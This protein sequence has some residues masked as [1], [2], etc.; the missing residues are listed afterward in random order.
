VCRVSAVSVCFVSLGSNRQADMSAYAITKQ[1]NAQLAKDGIQI[2]AP[3]TAQVC[4][5]KKATSPP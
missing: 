4:E 1:L 2:R 3:V 5:R